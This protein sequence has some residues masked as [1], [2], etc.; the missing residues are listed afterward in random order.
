MHRDLEASPG[1][2]G[3]DASAPPPPDLRIEMGPKAV[4]MAR[5]QLDKR[6]TPDAALRVGLRGGGCSGYSYVM[7][8]ADGPPRAKDRVFEFGGVRVYV[9]P[10]SL[11]LMNGTRLDYE[12]GLMGHGFKFVN[13]R[14]KGTCGCGES[15]QF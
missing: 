15:I 9:D 7:E 14:V 8:F 12:T 4:E 2:D 5:R 6:G 13:P 1:R 11:V 3:I 10:R